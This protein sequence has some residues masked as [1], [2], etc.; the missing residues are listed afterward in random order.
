M[1][2]WLRSEYEDFLAGSYIVYLY[3]SGQLGGY[4]L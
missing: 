2:G 4:W 1:R 3:A